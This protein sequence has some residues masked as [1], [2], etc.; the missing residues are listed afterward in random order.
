[1]VGIG[2]L[3]A[4]YSDALN[5]EGPFYYIEGLAKGNEDGV[6]YRDSCY[7]QYARKFGSGASTSYEKVSSGCIVF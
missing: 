7:I 5:V 3:K 4:D 6:P 1:M 2:I